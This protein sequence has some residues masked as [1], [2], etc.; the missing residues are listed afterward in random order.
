[1]SKFILVTNIDISE[2]NDKS[3]ITITLDLRHGESLEFDL[4]EKEAFE[5]AMLLAS[6]VQDWKSIKLPRNNKK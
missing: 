4:H 3:M 5:F 2:P 1:M 6:K